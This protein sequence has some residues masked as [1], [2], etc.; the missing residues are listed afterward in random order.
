MA[1]P[2]LNTNVFQ[3]GGQFYQADIGLIANYGGIS[4]R[5]IERA[6]ILARWQ[7]VSDYPEHGFIDRDAAGQTGKAEQ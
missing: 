4:E 5:D 2:V 3:D 6:T 1:K 7:F